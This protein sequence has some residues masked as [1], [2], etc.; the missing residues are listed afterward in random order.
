MI[1]LCESPRI[2]FRLNNNSGYITEV[3]ISNYQTME[4]HYGISGGPYE[5]IQYNNIPDIVP[6]E[7]SDQSTILMYSV[8]GKVKAINNPISKN[9]NKMRILGLIAL[10]SYMVVILFTWI[11][12]NLNGNVYF[13]AGEPIL[14]IK[15]LEWGIGFIGIYVAVEY[16]LKEIQ[17]FPHK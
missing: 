1:Q 12:A 2:N 10:I 9:L 3:Y 8:N 15:Y 13:L 4:N 14:L 7:N 16:L 5:S 17:G 11:Y 6:A